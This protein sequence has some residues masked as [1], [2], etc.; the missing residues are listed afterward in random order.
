[1]S[2][3]SDPTTTIRYARMEEVIK[4]IKRHGPQ[5]LEQLLARTGMNHQQFKDMRYEMPG[6]LCLEAYGFVMPRP[7]ASEGHVYKL[8]E[9]YHTGIPDEDGESNLQTAF[10]DVLT[11]QSTI[12]MDVDRIL[13]QMTQK[14][15]L[16]KM[17]KN[18]K[19]DLESVVSKMGDIA[20]ISNA[21]KSQWAG[22]VLELIA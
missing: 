12:Y 5:T 17:L 16:R 20:D 2:R 13:D 7:V 10:S 22:H 21:P 6:R 8:V 18:L 1:M 4:I 19:R 11:R 15:A 14:T 9:K 3:P